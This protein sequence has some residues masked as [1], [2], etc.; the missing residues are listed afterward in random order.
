MASCEAQ[1]LKLKVI[2]K[3]FTA[4]EIADRALQNHLIQKDYDAPLK[5][6]FPFYSKLP[7]T[8]QKL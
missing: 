4:K 6:N 8:H 7:V 5:V 3:P 1:L 2:E